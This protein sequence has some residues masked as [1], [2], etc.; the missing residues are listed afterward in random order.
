MVLFGDAQCEVGHAQFGVGRRAAGD[1]EALCTVVAA[2]G[3]QAVVVT[4]VLVRVQGGGCLQGRAAG[5]EGVVQGGEDAAAALVGED[6]PEV[7]F[8]PGDAARAEPVED[9]L[10]PVPGK[11]AVRE[12]RVVAVVGV[13][14]GAGVGEVATPAAGDA[15]FC[16]GFGIV[17]EQ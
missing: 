8:V 4:V 11:R 6:L 16:A 5:M 10:R 2:A 7:F 3:V 17:V 12:V 9:V 13:G 15:D 1:D 14:T